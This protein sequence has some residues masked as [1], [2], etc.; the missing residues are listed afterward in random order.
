MK[1]I[2]D[3]KDLVHSNVY[4]LSISLK[5]A[6]PLTQ[7]IDS[8]YKSGIP[9]IIVDCKIDFENFNAFVGDNN[10]MYMLCFKHTNSFHQQALLI[11]F[12]FFEHIKRIVI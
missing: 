3:V 1:E 11:N 8:V 12:K 4:V 7:K 6:K 2:E 10:L 5:K 9:V